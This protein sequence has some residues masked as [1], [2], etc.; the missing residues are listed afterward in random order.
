VNAKRPQV[1]TFAVVALLG[2]GRGAGGTDHASGSASAPASA[3]PPSASAG[4]V[5]RA[6]AVP[7]APPP[8][9]VPPS[10]FAGAKSEKACRAQTI[11]VEKYQTRGEIALAGQEDGVAVV[12]RLRLAGKRDEQ[13]AFASFDEQGRRKARAR[14]VGLTTHDIPP[15]VFGA[16]SEQVVVWFD[17]KGLAYARPKADALAS[18]ENGHVGAV[19]PEVADDVALAP[20][21]AGGGVAAAPFGA[22]KSQLGL[23]V[24]AAGEGAAVKAMGVTHYA[25]APHHPAIAASASGTM[26][27]WEDGGALVASRFDAAGK[28]GASACTIAPAGSTKYERLSLATTPAGAIAMW[29]EGSAVRTRALDASG[30]PA[31]PIWT[32]ADG[33]WATITSLGEGALLGWV[34]ADGRFLAAKLAPTGAPPARGIDASEGTSGVKDP[35]ALVT[36]GARA[37]FAWAEAM[38]PAVSTKRLNVRVVDVACVP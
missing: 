1:L 12:W 34:A 20:W 2:C 5:A 29:M 6:S 15:R 16:G 30:C 35:P 37:A 10:T 24:F 18:A 19:G 32:A 28:E 26:V 38:G 8:G 13:I 27:A 21:P 7:D 31:S 23:F 36:F 9:V 25:K 33:K 11:E 4:P 3:P 17:D 22:G 14:A